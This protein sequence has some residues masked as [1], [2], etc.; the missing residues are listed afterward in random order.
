MIRSSEIFIV[1]FRFSSS[2]DFFEMHRKRAVRDTVEGK[3]KTQTCRK[4]EECFK[5]K[6]VSIFKSVRWIFLFLRTTF[7]INKEP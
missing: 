6:K 2:P 7:L 5:K 4:K 1:F 3:K